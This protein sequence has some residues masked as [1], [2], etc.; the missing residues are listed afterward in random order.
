MVEHVR[1][2]IAQT[3]LPFARNAQMQHAKNV[4]SASMSIQMV[5]VHRVQVFYVFQP[6]DPTTQTAKQTYMIAQLMQKFNLI[7]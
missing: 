2:P 5:L 6:L 3:Y 4:L 1:L 7:W